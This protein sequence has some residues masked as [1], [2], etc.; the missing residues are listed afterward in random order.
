MAKTYQLAYRNIQTD[1]WACRRTLQWSF[2][3]KSFYMYLL[4][5]PRITYCGIFSLPMVLAV[6]ET[7]LQEKEIISLLEKMQ[8]KYERIAWSPET[9]EVCILHWLEYNK[10]NEK[11]K[12]GFDIALQ[13]VKNK[14]LV[15]YL[16]GMDRVCIGY[17]MGMDSNNNAS[18]SNLCSFVLKDSYKEIM[19][20]WNEITGLAKIDCI[21][22]KRKESVD[23]RLKDKGI[24]K[25]LQ[26]IEN[27][28]V[29]PFLLGEVKD[30]DGKNF[31]ASFDWC[32]APNNFQKVLDG[33]YIRGKAD[34]TLEEEVARRIKEM[35]KYAAAGDTK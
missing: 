4:T 24:E 3:E 25:F 8:N 32:I 17:A 11:Q 13:A 15:D 22:H 26:M 12:V 35:E 16:M 29:S 34:E 31:K 1:F 33:N 10:F 6:A 20:K 2:K 14:K 21:E 18:S 9:E 28:K 27:V 30:R 5:N 7:G 23:A 19:Q